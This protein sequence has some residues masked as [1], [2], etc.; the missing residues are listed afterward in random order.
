MQVGCGVRTMT[1]KNRE[2]VYIWH[3]ETKDGRR[4]AVH[5]YIGP[6]KDPESGRKA[7]EALEAYTRRAIEDAR[8]RLQVVRVRAMAA[9]R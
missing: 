2:Y 1:V 9:S 6:A 8:R 3:Y 7:V 5:E 4:R